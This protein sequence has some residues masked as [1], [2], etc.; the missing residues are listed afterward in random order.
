[1]MNTDS[2]NDEYN[3]PPDYDEYTDCRRTCAARRNP[4]AE[5]VCAELDDNDYYNNLN[6]GILGR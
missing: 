6:E 5:C 1:M 4:N 3:Y 2:R